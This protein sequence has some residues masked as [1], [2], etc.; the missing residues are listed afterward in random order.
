[1]HNTFFAGD[2]HLGHGRVFEFE[3]EHRP[4]KTVDEHDEAIVERWNAV[5]KPKDTVWHMGDVMFGKTSEK[6]L[7]RLNGIKKLV[8]GNHDIYSAEFYL[9]YFN[10]VNGAVKYETTVDGVKCRLI[11]THVPIHPSQFYRFTANVHGHLHSDTIT[12]DLRYINT[13]IEQNNLQPISIEEI[14]MRLKP[15]LPQQ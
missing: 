10:S 13:S 15:L 9:R 14:K 3:P 12:G 4:F 6:Y 1:M 2:T 5:V 7:A 11:L 8:M